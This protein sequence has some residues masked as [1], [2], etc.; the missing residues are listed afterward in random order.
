MY[1]GGDV[2]ERVNGSAADSVD[3][4]TQVV[5]SKRPGQAIDLTVLRGRK[6]KTIKVTLSREPPPN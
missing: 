2:I 1:V 5:A 6:V 3:A 4:L